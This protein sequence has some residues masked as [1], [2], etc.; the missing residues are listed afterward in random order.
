MHNASTTSTEL[1]HL[2]SEQAAWLAFFND[3]FACLL[4]PL[5]GGHATQQWPRRF[6]QSHRWVPLSTA[7]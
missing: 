2:D 5:L 6:Q 1:H 4:L 7:F 3:G